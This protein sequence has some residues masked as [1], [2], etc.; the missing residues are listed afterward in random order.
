MS[1]GWLLAQMW[2][3]FGHARWCV[4]ACV[5]GAP[6]PLPPGGRP[7]SR[8]REACPHAIIQCRHPDSKFQTDLPSAYEGVFVKETHTAHFIS[9][10]LNIYTYIWASVGTLVLGLENVKFRSEKM[11]TPTCPPPSI[12]HSISRNRQQI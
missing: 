3:E 2:L 1:L 11:Y 6:P 8:G 4:H 5:C 10:L 7:W 12:L 9:E